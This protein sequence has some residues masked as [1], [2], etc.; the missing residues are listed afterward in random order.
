MNGNRRSNS[1]V[2][3]PFVFAPP[4]PMRGADGVFATSIAGERVELHAE[5]ALFWP[6]ERS[7]FVA[8][9]HLGKAAAFRAGGVPLPRGSTAAD[10]LRLTR[11][12]ERTRA[13]RLIVLGDFLHARAGRVAALAQAFI[14][15]RAQHARIDMLLVRGN[16]DAHAGDPP[17]EWRVA[18]AD[19]PYALPPFLACH[20]VETPPSGFALCGHVHPGVRIHGAG[21]SVRLPCFVLGSRHAILPAF[22]R[23]TG[24]AE[25]ARMRDERIVAIADRELFELP[26]SS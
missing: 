5:R 26:R 12:L 24:L 23:F 6:R 22:G 4:P 16:H 19:E 1:A 21:E 3:L 2:S 17:A 13:T 8:D 15:W 9:I 18:C 20:H 11:L 25:V 10:L 7:L 14:A